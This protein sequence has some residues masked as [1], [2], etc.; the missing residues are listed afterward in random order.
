MNYPKSFPKDMTDWQAIQDNYN[1]MEDNTPLMVAPEDVV[2]P[3]P[4]R[5]PAQIPPQEMMEEPGLASTTTRS[6][7]QDM[8][9]TTPTVDQSR[10]EQLWQEYSQLMGDDRK[11]LA[12]ARNRDRMLKLGAAAGD[13]IATLINARNQMNV[14]APG[15]QVQQGAGL[16]KIADIAARAP[17]IQTDLTERRADLLAQYRAL[18]EGDSR[19][20]Q[21]RRI[22]AYEKQVDNAGKKAN[23]TLEKPTVGEQTVDREFAKKYNEWRTGGKADFEENKK[24]FDEAIT[25]LEKGS[26]DTGMTSGIG[27]RLPGVRTD[28]RELETRVRKALN[29]MLRAT[30]GAQFT[31]EEGERIFQQT[32]DPF[33]S[34]DENVKNMQTELSKIEKRARDIEQQGQ[35]FDKQKTL[36]G[37]QPS[38]ESA[39]APMQ[40]SPKDQKALD[41]ANKNPNDPRSEQIKRKI[42]NVNGRQF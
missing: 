33:A 24:I 38:T 40:L 25:G 27:A 6:M 15:V 4:V 23:A 41:W 26:V 5:Q 20:L 1:A 16:V 31:Q 3:E 39:P 11:A 36:S 2:V 32:F 37:F 42:R 34:P 18:A 30:L 29:S 8:T 35:L 10:A 9:D 12:D 28:T 14:A 17:E 21:R 19:D 22:A 7:S 13:T